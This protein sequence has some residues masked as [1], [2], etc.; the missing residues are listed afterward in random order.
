MLSLHALCCGLPIMAVMLVAASGAASGATAFAVSS[1][2]L[3]A[4][5][6]AHELW[7]LGLSAAFVAL[8]AVLEIRARRGGARHGFP[9]LFMLSLGCF[10]A[11]LTIVGLHQSL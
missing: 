7:I 3:H 5:L 1:G 9:W 10:L 2:E 4:A 8:G 6:H 11:N